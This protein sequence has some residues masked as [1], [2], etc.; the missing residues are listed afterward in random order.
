MNIFKMEVKNSQLAKTGIV[1]YVVLIILL[2]IG[3][4]FSN[5]FTAI[6][7]IVLGLFL[8][9]ARK[10]V[11]KEGDITIGACLYILYWALS[12]VTFS[13]SSIV[14][15]PLAAFGIIDMAMLPDL[16]PG[17]LRWILK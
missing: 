8:F 5:I 9:A 11:K 12:I 1:A 3:F 4:L 17:F 10:A 13:L 16:A 6:D 14:L 15:L 7:I 2:F